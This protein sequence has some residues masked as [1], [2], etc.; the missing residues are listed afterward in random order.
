MILSVHLA[1]LRTRPALRALRTPVAA[2][3][4]LWGESLAAVPLA[5]PLF[6]PPRP[7]GVGLVA[8]WED[9]GALDDSLARAPLAE[10]FAGGWHVR[11]EP[12]R[13]FGAWAALPGL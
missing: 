10:R 5:A 1:P 6:P 12:L 2:P 8:A 3:G 7:L 11:L 4:L 9:D 13:A